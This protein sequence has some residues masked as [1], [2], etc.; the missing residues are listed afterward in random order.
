MSTLI[1]G[2]DAKVMVNGNT[3]L[4]SEWSLESMYI[5]AEAHNTTDGTKRVIG[6]QDSK[7]SV[8]GFRDP[9][10]PIEG[11][12]AQN[13]PAVVKLYQD[14]TKFWQGTYLLPSLKVDCVM[15]EAESWE[16]TGEQESG[17]LVKPV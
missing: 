4:N 10:S 9:A 13:A 7:I 2:K 6:R 11:S 3:L 15:D 5:L 8:K 12:V 16:F 17:T 14:T 1:T